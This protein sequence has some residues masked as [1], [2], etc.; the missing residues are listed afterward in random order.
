MT[1]SNDGWHL[2]IEKI[3]YGYPAETMENREFAVDKLFYPQAF[4]KLYLSFR[5]KWGKHTKKSGLGLKSVN[6]LL[7]F[8]SP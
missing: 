2:L 7:K 1:F 6:K 4:F 5:K 8:K 3:L